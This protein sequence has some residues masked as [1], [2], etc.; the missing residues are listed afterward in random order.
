[1]SKA[2]Q[3]GDKIHC[4]NWKDLKRTAL[5]LSSQGYGVTVI[6]FADMS[7]DTLTITALP[8]EGDTE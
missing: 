6:G 8:E 5:S 1:M 4:K 3:L 7:A 2:L